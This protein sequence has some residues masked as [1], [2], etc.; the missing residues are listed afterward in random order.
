M[1]G[2]GKEASEFKSIFQNFLAL[3]SMHG[4]GGKERL[5]LSIEVYLPKLQHCPLCIDREG[6]G[7]EASEFKSIFQNP[8]ALPSTHGRGGK[9]TTH[10][11]KFNLKDTAL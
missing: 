3:P 2:K 8:S 11:S 5:G 4:R 7:K 10:L 9:E 1:G 6:K